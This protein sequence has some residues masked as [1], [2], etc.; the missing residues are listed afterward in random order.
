[1]SSLSIITLAIRSVLNRK[2]TA[3]LTILTVAITVSLFIG[4]EKMRH[5]A[6]ESFEN[7]I[8]G[9][10]LIVG[11]RS[12]PINLLLYSVFH[13]GDPTNAIS[14]DSYE[15]VSN[16]PGVSWTVPLSMG[17]SHKGYRVVG[18]TN[19]YFEHYQYANS[20]SL[21]FNHGGPLEELHSA[22]IGAVV[23]R[24]Q[25]YEVGDEIIIAHG[26]GEVSFIEHDTD[27]F[28][29]T[30]I[31]S[32][33]GTPVDQSVLVGLEAIDVIHQD[34]SQ[35]TDNSGIDDHEYGEALEDD[36]H[37]H[38]HEPDQISAFLVGLDNPSIVLSLQR[39]INT[40]PDE[41]LTAV[42]P[43]VALISLWEVV[44][45]VERSLVAI[46]ALVV[47]TG[48]V[49]I[50]S[51]ILTSLNERRRE[52][53]ILRAV[54]ARPGH[55]FVLLVSEA[56]VLALAGAIAGVGLTYGALSVIGP[57]LETRYGLTLIG[58]EPSLYDVAIIAIVTLAAGLL[59]M[60]PAWRA[61]RNSLAD[62]M[63]IRV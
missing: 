9:T 51:S 54:G 48:L 47:L 52:M 19:A 31:L 20:Q 25:G 5:G 15:A 10:D 45:A 63:T 14:W 21:N 18:T 33:T 50:L 28:V 4:I 7:T 40:Y 62:G 35:V 13:I 60:I 27:P 44:G 41:P 58:L 1:M 23:A 30:G 3:L 49:T 2:A 29:I 59:G 37:D 24:E 6:R 32:P 38:V 16:A 57:Y 39:Q 61:F 43:G 56:A 34:G 46:A 42:M 22:V 26:L 11:A 53:A 17:D 55:I 8:S 12:G 36:D